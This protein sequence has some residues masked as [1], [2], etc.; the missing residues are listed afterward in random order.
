MSLAENINS[1]IKSAMLAKDKRKLEALR[2]IKAGLLLAKTGKDVSSGE[3]P[4]SVEMQLLQKL[5]KQRKES[6][7][8]Y[9]SQNRSDLAEDE[10]FQAGII[11]TYLPQQMS[12]GEIS[13]AVRE[14]VEQTGASGM[15]DMGKV[16]GAATKKLAGKADN[17]T[18]STI[19][20]EML[21]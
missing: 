12:A 5:V 15:K 4:E 18:I 19:V 20:K 9:K 1:D 3:I 16:M 6:A 2:A 17:K 8:I 14:I 21:G 10:L 13:A 7:E 11:E